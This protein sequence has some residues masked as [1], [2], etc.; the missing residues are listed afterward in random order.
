MATDERWNYSDC[1]HALMR[2][3]DSA[4]RQ[5]WPVSRHFQW[6][7]R[8]CV[9]LLV[10]DV[11]CNE[12]L[13]SPKSTTPPPPP[14][15]ASANVVFQLTQSTVLLLLLQ[16]NSSVVHTRHHKSWHN[17]HR[18][19]SRLSQKPCLV[20]LWHTRSVCFSPQTLH[21]AY[22]LPSV[23]FACWQSLAHLPNRPR[24]FPLPYCNIFW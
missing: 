19:N 12:V 24:T 22:G 5:L 6:P 2:F 10:L 8:Q 11:G 1:W 16:L 3:F 9:W 14:P 13:I 17:V 7:W 15:R 21:Q 18:L 20:D 23:Y 4:A